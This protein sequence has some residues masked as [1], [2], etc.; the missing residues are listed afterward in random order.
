M[1]F[2]LLEL[3]G[4][5]SCEAVCSVHSIC[6]WMEVHVQCSWELLA[7]PIGLGDL[8]WQFPT[9]QGTYSRRFLLPEG[10]IVAV[11]L[12][13]NGQCYVSRCIT[14]MSKTFLWV[15]LPATEYE[16]RLFRNPDSPYHVPRR[17]TS[18]TVTVDIRNRDCSLQEPWQFT[19]GIHQ[20]SFQ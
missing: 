5:S 12:V 19:P 8:R 6:R 20:V 14:E 3:L 10:L 17:F 15:T 7:P 1:F 13:P 11:F 16:L 4:S 18:G 2:P 9:T